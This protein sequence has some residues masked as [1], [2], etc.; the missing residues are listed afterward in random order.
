MKVFPYILTRIGGGSFENLAQVDYSGLTVQ[1]ARLLLLKKEKIKFKQHLCDRLLESIKA[2]P[3]Q[4]IQNQVQNVRR[5]IFN[6]RPVKPQVLVNARQH[7][8]AGLIA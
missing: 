1:T 8:P 5:D 7:L 4:K 2:M 6:Q 3:D